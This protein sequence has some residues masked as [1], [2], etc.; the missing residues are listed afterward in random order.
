MPFITALHRGK[1]CLAIVGVGAV[2]RIGPGNG[3]REIANDLPMRKQKLRLLSVCK[4]QWTQQEARSLER[5]NHVFRMITQTQ[6][7]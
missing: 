5:R 3:F 4:L 1:S 2:R 6:W 7:S